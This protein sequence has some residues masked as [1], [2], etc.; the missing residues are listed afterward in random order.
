WQVN[1]VNVAGATGPTFTSTTLVNGQIVT[2]VLTTPS[3][4]GPLSATSNGLTI[5]VNPVVSVN[6]GPDKT[7]MEGE[8]VELEGTANGTFPITW[9]PNLGF[10]FP[11]NNPLRPTVAPVIT[12]T[13]TLAAQVGAC[14]SQSQVTI[15][16]TPRVRIP[17]AFTPNGDGQDDTWQID[18]IGDYASNHVTV[19]NRWGAKLFETTNYSRGNEWNG[20]IN[21]QPAPIGTYYYLI[22]LGNGKSY[23]GPLTVFY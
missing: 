4:C 6:A 11:N 19:F 18:R 23:T 14:S 3:P 10:T 21:G 5:D 8:T 17:N 13:Y 12:T 1:G 22:T 16:V 2:L 9:T 7:I 20:T 15:T